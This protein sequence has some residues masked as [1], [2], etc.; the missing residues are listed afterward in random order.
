M[1]FSI[2]DLEKIIN[3]SNNI[4]FFGGAGVST[5][6]GLKDFRSSDGLYHHTFK[7]YRP[8][9]ILS[10]NFFYQHTDIFY[11]YYRSVFLDS[12]VKPNDAHYFLAE[13]ERSGKLKAVIT[14]N[15]DG[16]HQMAGSKKVIELHGSIYRNYTVKSNKLIKGIDCITNTSSIPYDTNGELIKP[17]VVLYG[18]PLND[19]VLNEAIQYIRNADCLI[20]GGTSL[21]VYPAAQL[22]HYFGGTYL[23]GIN[24]EKLGIPYFIQ[25]PIDKVFKKINLKK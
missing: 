11:E 12:G 25:G 4:V 20:V 19:D 15:I 3:M 18:E 24:K 10:H 9:T 6:S 2:S 21:S 13:L 7:G 23:I 5:A 1:T 22:I 16:L 8:E 14:Q 17:D